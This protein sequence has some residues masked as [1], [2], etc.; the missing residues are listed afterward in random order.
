[1]ALPIRNAAYV[2]MEHSAIIG[3]FDAG[4]E[5]LESKGQQVEMKREVAQLKDLTRH[6]CPSGHG[7]DN[8]GPK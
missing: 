2:W 1:M 6:T 5:G 8:G 3:N 4:P 7:S